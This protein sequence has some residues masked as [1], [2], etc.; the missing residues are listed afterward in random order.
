MAERDLSLPVELSTANHDLHDRERQFRLLVSSVHGHALYMLDPNGFIASWNAGAEWIK[1]YSAQEILGRHYSTFFT[2]SDRAAGEPEHVLEFARK[3]GRFE[4]EAQ[5]VRKDGTLFWAN[6]VTEPIHDEAGMLIGYAQL[7]LD[8]TERMLV[9]DELRNA[10]EFLNLVIENIPEAILVKDVDNRRFTMVNHAAEKLIGMSRAEIIGKTAEAIYPDDY[11][12]TVRQEDEDLLKRGELFIDDHIIELRAKE[13]QVVTLNRKLLYDDKG[14]PRYMLAVI[15]DITARK[16]A[17]ERIAHLARHDSLTDLPN[18]AAFNDR[19]ATALATAADKGARFALLA[20]DLDRLKEVNDVLGHAAGDRL[21]CEVSN[22]LSRAAGTAFLARLGG[23]EFA[24]ITEEAMTTAHLVAL[25]DRLLAVVDHDIDIQG[26]QIRPSFSIG[27]AVFPDDGHDATTLLGNADAALYRAK[28]DGRGV[29]RFF[30]ADMDKRQRER[31]ALRHD[32]GMAI[33]RGEFRM[34]FQPQAKISG[35]I[36]G[37]EALL[38]WWHPQRGTVSP[39][40]FIPVAE[41]SRLIISIGEWAL[42]AACREAASW[43]RPLG[44]AVDLSPVQFQSGDL[45]GLVHSVLLETGL[46]ADRLELEITE[47]VL[48][49]DSARGIAVLRRLK[50]LGVRIAMDDFG[51]GYSSLSYLQSFPFDKIKIDRAFVSNVTRNR[52]SAAIVRAVLGL[53]HGLGLP[54]LAEGV[55]AEEELAFLTAEG[56]DE[57]QG[58]LIGRAHP[59]EF[60]DALVGRSTDFAGLRLACD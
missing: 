49:D 18:R 52:Q 20:I 19:L 58:H 47:G 12:L 44:V 41:E 25:A 4:A 30:K 31:H 39:G 28:A 50:A 9:K 35:E 7:T 27:V 11:A 42:R 13:S 3:H 10:R 14:V 43:P 23:D 40:E 16:R 15:H 22:R 51:K 45:P 32:L 38:R 29:T 60:Y 55:E 37:F 53:A 17:E 26:T 33:E 54:V 24:L 6:V 57:V 48:I 5:R 59:I 46:S 36:I 1:G 2:V 21:L 56:C 34:F 8:I